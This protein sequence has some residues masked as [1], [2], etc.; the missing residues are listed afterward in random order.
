MKLPDAEV[1]LTLLDEYENVPC[2][3]IVY[4]LIPNEEYTS[5][6]TLPDFVPLF[7]SVKYKVSVDTV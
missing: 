5:L 3:V 4:N 1:V 2:T 6:E 7:V